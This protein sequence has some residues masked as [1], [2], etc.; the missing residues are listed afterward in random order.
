MV[1]KI[2]KSNLLRLW[3]IMPDWRA[4]K[5]IRSLGDWRDDTV[6]SS[7]TNELAADGIFVEEIPTWGAKLMA[8]QGS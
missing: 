5:V 4:L 7:N 6:L 1:G 8:P 2:E 3:N